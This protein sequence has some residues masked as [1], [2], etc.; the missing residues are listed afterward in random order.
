MAGQGQIIERGKGKYLVR[1]YL[2]TDARGK[3]K[4]HNKTITTGKKDAQA[5]LTKVLRERDLGIFVDPSKENLS[6][7][8]DTWLETAARPRV[9]PKTYQGYKPVSYTHLDVYKR[10]RSRRSKM[11]TVTRQR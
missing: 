11:Q 2:G 10:Q 3:R 4:Y 8:L 5:Y 9:R 7:Y 1:V 6:E